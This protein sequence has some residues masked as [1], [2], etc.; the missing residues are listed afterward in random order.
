MKHNLP[1]CNLAWQAFPEAASV[2]DEDGDT[3]L[4]LA[5][6]KQHPPDVVVVTL[7]HHDALPMPTL[8]SRP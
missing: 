7:P 6:Y 5:L 4:H 3:P 1:L 8:I 2:Q